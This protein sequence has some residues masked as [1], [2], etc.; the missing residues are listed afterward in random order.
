M[1]ETTQQYMQRILG[2]IEGKDPLAVLQATPRRIERLVTAAT[3]KRLAARPAP[4]KWSVTEI[5][6]HLAD[7]EIVQGVRLRMILGASGTPLQGFN[8]EVW[9]AFSEYASHDP[10]LSLEAYKVNRER[11]LR[12]LKSL[13]P[14]MWKCYGMHSERGKETVKRITEMMAGHDINHAGQIEALLKG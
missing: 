11:T 6:A 10:R 14:K 4:E 8:Q 9:A 5:L 3:K 2:Y 1:K 7:V 12:L 13:P